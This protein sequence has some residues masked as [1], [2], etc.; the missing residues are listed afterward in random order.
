MSSNH[1]QPQS[2]P[3]RRS[4]GSVSSSTTPTPHS[5]SYS[6]PAAFYKPGTVG[7]LKPI[8]VVAMDIKTTVL[9]VDAVLIGSSNGVSGI[10]TDK[11]LAYRVVSARKHPKETLCASIMTKDPVKVLASDSAT[12]AL[13]AMISGQFRH[14][15]VLDPRDN[16]VMGLL[17]VTKC[18]YDSLEKLETVYSNSRRDVL[19]AAKSFTDQELINASISTNVDG[20]FIQSERSGVNDT[21]PVSSTAEATM[22]RYAELL[23]HQL[24]GPNLG[25]LLTPDMVPPVV[26]MRDSVTTACQK[27]Q[28]ANETAVLVFDSDA[29]AGEDGLGNLCGIFTTKD[30]VLRVLAANLDPQTTVIARVLTPHPECVTPET[31]VLEALRKM[32]VGRYLHLPVID[33]EGVIE[34]LVD[35]LK[36][37]YTTLNQISQIQGTDNNGPMWDRFWEDA[38]SVVSGDGQQKQ[39]PPQGA[40]TAGRPRPM[41]RSHNHTTQRTKSY[42]DR[43]RRNSSEIHDET[44]TIFPDDSASVVAMDSYY[45]HPHVLGPS[46][47]GGGGSGVGGKAQSVASSSHHHDGMFAFKLK[48]F[49]RGTTHRFT[50]PVDSLHALKESMNKKLEKSV[51]AVCY[52]DDEEDCVRLDT[53]AD[54]V[55]AVDI[56]KRCGW[57]RVVVFCE[58][59]RELY[60]NRGTS[61]AGTTFTK[62]GGDAGE[63]VVGGGAGTRLVSVKEVEQMEAMI[64]PGLVGASIAVVCAFLLGRAFK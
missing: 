14:L 50:A 2:R 56:A 8:P 63:S 4:N 42:R 58:S 47:S 20:S 32:H 53:D 12:T 26:G 48:D 18:L 22:S 37:T 3:R 29:G 45:S 6:K 39:H 62:R 57:G 40:A 28:E 46:Y 30:L 52:L 7:A 24:G 31:P 16:V 21:S 33:S 27:M 17:D 51:D 15:P 11:D 55:E 54:L 36:L 5:G 41:S 13:N 43:E 35:V 59:Q 34:G 19:R 49:E 25:S 61:E 38:S 64:V 9:E 44:A 60:E 23:R 1:T 10:V